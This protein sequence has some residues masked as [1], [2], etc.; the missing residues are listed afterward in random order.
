MPA[1]RD[2]VRQAWDAV[3]EAYAANRR[4]NGP[5]ADL[6]DELVADLPAEAIVLD[7]AAATESEPSRTSSARRTR[8]A[9]ISRGRDS[10][11]RV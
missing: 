8:L 4:A 10:N 2:A 7:V 1:E 5:D 6:I 11:W 9:S 3:S